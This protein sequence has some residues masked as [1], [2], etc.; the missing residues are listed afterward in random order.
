VQCNYNTSTQAPAIGQLQSVINNEDPLHLYT[1]NPYLKQPY[2]HNLSIQYNGTSSSGKNNLS[3]SVT[4]AYVQHN[5]TSASVLAQADSTLPDNIIL[6]RGSQLTVPVNVDANATV[7]SNISYAIPIAFIKS[8]LNLSLNGGMAHVPGLINNQMNYQDNKSAGAGISLSSNI[9]ENLDFI[10]SSNTSLVTNENSIN[11]Q[12]NTRYIS[13]N[14]RATIN[15][16][17]G[18]GLVFNSSLSY[19][20]NAGLTGGFDR[21]YLLC[22]MSIGK[23]IF[24]KHQGDIRVTVYDL[25]NENSNIQHVVTDVYVQDS[26][27]NILQR[28]FLLVF[29]YKISN[30]KSG[31][32]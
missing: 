2:R 13:E 14:A 27:S 8:R 15:L 24:K 10:L 29:T 23:K 3:A 28:Y 32:H 9:S 25:F 19:Q 31:A 30:F 7:N 4:G 16:I 11:R 6:P 12:L 20:S 21:K 1:G 18:S 5:I 26:R 17:S 22:N